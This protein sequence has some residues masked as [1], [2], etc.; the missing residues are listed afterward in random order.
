MKFDKCLKKT[1]N[2]MEAYKYINQICITIF[3]ENTLEIFY[4]S[5][6]AH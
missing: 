6:E 1:E 4:Y 5:I 3:L 2:S